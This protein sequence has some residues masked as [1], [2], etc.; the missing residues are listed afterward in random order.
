M[1]LGLALG[2]GGIKGIAHLG[3]IKYLEEKNIDIQYISGCS[4][5]SIIATLYACGYTSDEIYSLVKFYVNKILKSI[6]K[7]KISSLF[8]KKNVMGINSGS[9]IENIINKCCKD[10]GIEDISQIPLP[11]FIPTVD[12]HTGQL[13]YFTNVHVNNRY[14]DTIKYIYGGNI[15]AIVRASC[16]YPG[17]FAPKQYENYLLV[18]GGLRDNVP[19][20]PLVESFTNNVLAVTFTDDKIDNVNNIFDVITQSFSILAHDSKYES[21]KNAK[22]ILNIM[23][24]K[25]KLLD[26]TKIDYVYNQGYEQARNI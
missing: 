13:I 5:G 15:G 24:D 17:V 16:S 6:V 20:M 26:Y 3:V 12:L 25:V 23:L 9:M 7:N 1:S 2:G 22:Y 18:D 4:S 21:L 14:L 8:T 10:K 11:I 19:V